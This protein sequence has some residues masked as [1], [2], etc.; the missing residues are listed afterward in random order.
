MNVELVYILNKKKS[1]YSAIYQ[2]IVIDPRCLTNDVTMKYKRSSSQE[3]HIKYV[4]NVSWLLYYVLGC[5][6]FS[7]FKHHCNTWPLLLPSCFIHNVA[8]I[9]FL[10]L[11][12][13]L[14]YSCC[15][16]TSF[17]FFAVFVVTPC[18]SCFV[19]TFTIKID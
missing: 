13:F 9:L 7:I 10:S 19:R 18:A 2:S 4:Y 12:L 1:I 16:L 11:S 8:W 17:I 15:V 3:E 6:N 5:N 14:F